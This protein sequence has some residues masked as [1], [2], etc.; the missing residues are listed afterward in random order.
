MISLA[1]RAWLPESSSTQPSPSTTRLSAVITKSAEKRNISKKMFRT[2]NSILSMNGRNAGL[3]TGS[4]QTSRT[5]APSTSLQIEPRRKAE[6]AASHAR[7]TAKSGTWNA[8]GGGRGIRRRHG[9]L[10][11]G[12][13]GQLLLRGSRLVPQRLRQRFGRTARRRRG[14][15]FG[16]ISIGGGGEVFRHRSERHLDHRAADLDLV[17]PGDR[18]LVDALAIDVGA[19]HAAH[20]DDRQRALGGDFDHRVDPRDLLVIQTQMS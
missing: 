12:R 9:R 11:G 14:R 3:G 6:R 4:K 15:A 8:R 7:L 13:R 18:A 19:F 17:A 1:I 20:V 16:K 10:G 5:I 2:V